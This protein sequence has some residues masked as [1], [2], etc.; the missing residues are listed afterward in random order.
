M[1][2]KPSFFRII[3]NDYV[4]YTCIAFLLICLIVI[5][6]SSFL[7]A[8]GTAIFLLFLVIGSMIA[9]TIVVARLA[10]FY[11]IFN[12][13]TGVEA[14]ISRVVCFR[15]QISVSL[16]YGYQ[17]ELRTCKQIF[18]KNA[19]TSRYS[20]GDEVV[21]LIDPNNPQRAVIKELFQ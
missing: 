15:N 5:L 2:S 9:G 1:P 21:V 18:L 16:Q 19:A 13:G 4:T 17:G 3:S 12:F 6:V 14:V 7:T 20:V 10:L 11:R 8:G